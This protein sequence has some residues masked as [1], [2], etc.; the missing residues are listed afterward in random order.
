MATP[1]ATINSAKPETTIGESNSSCSPWL[2][3]KG[4]SQFFSA[5]PR[6]NKKPEVTEPIARIAIGNHIRIGDS[7]GCWLSSQRFVLVK[8]KIITRVI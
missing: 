1:I 3:N 4:S 8:V 7:C 5:L 6:D 2:S